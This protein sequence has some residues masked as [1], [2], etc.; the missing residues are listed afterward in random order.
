[1]EPNMNVQHGHTDTHVVVVFPRAI[2]NIMLT[3]EQAESFIA[4]MQNSLA[5]LR[6][7]GKNP[8]P[9]PSQGPAANG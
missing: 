4:S 9:L 7:H 5:N 2:P 6:E 3:P 8:K 1:M